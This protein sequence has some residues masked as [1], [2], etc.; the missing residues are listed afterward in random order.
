MYMDN[1]HDEIIRKQ[2]ET[3]GNLINNSLRNLT[4]SMERENCKGP[5]YEKPVEDKHDN[6]VPFP[7]NRRA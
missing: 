5:S 1:Y 2:M 6:I 7:I 4:E 3:I